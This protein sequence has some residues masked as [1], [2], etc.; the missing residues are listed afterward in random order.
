MRQ[1]NYTILLGTLL[2]AACAAV[3]SCAPIN[4]TTRVKL[5]PRRY[6]ENYNYPNVNAVRSSENLRP[7]V[8]YSD[9]SGNMTTVKPGG[10]LEHTELGFMDPLIVVASYGEYYKLIRYPAKLKGL[11]LA[12]RPEVEYCGWLHR[13]RLLLY[14]NSLTEIRNGIKLKNLTAVQ[15]SRVVSEAARHFRSDSLILYS[16][17]RLAQ[18]TGRLMGVNNIAYVMK[19]AERDTR[20]L[21]GYRPVIRPELADSLVMGWV[22]ASLVAPFGQWLTTRRAPL[23]ENE[24][25]PLDTLRYDSLRPAVSPVR[26]FHPV[27]FADSRDNKLVY[28]TLDGSEVIDR[29]DN[30]IFNVDGEPI[31]WSLS[32]VIAAHLRRVNVIFAFE[33]T[34]NVVAQIPTITNAIQTA[35][36]VFE[37]S[38][39]EMS[40]QYAAVMG[41]SIVPFERDYMAFSDRVVE[42]SEG[43]RPTPASPANRA[44]AG[45]VRLAEMNP[46]STNL[47]V[48]V[49]E[50]SSTAEYPSREMADAFINNNCRLLSFQVFADKANSNVYNNF[51]LQ[52]TAIIEHYA[53]TAKV[54]KR[55]VIVYPDQ[56]HRQSRFKEISKNDYS[57][58]FPRRSMTQ[59]MVVFPEKGQMAGP[60]LLAGGIDSIVRQI[61]ADNRL[62]ISSMERAFREVGSHRHRYD[63][64]YARRFGEERGK[65][66][67]PE[68]KKAFENLSPHW[69]AI[70]H[71]VSNRVDAVDM[72]DFGLILTESELASLTMFVEKL[73]ARQ[74]D[75]ASQ[76]ERD[77]TKARRVRRVR[78]ELSGV[79]ADSQLDMMYSAETQEQ[80]EREFL[81]TGAVRRH[82]RKTYMDA[83]RKCAVDGPR[84]KLTLS[85]AH[86][87]ITTAPSVYPMLNN[88]T[89]K[90]IRRK[91]NLT[92]SELEQLLRYFEKQPPLL[93]KNAVPADEFNGPDGETYYL[94]PYEALP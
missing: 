80:S 59:G 87:Y 55:K 11:R 20:A 17:P 23:I 42:M 77:R 94:V 84:R 68:L 66:I 53:D 36:Q 6:S 82:L 13:D 4:S 46:H 58:D 19:Y 24:L 76:I 37:A 75:K 3:Q 67:S 43:L 57:L 93:R 86:E 5:V 35:N 25:Y 88:F 22:D 89:I 60:E 2:V 41:D 39:R 63:D 21:V 30:R 15:E 78:R 62:L 47:V 44:L 50:K 91:M 34:D 83:L 65:R 49:G 74:L 52:S 70:T 54:L 14:N 92:D 12:N 28:R 90:D 27:L 32:K 18:T 33:L 61:E 64:R 79:P 31:S 69:A 56:V 45:A 48:Y 72:A 73:A 29:S 71:R 38:P 1:K 9:R 26:S 51:V 7:W 40:Y 10:T 85:R 81:R 16:E 8:V